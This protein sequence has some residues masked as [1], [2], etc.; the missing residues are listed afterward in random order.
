MVAIPKGT[1][2]AGTPRNATPRYVLSDTE[3]P[4]LNAHT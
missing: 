3:Q 2:A 1:A 4:I